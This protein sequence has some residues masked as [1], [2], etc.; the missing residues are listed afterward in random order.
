MREMAQELLDRTHRADLRTRDRPAGTAMPAGFEVVEARRIEDSTMW[1]RYARKCHEIQARGCKGL[2]VRT[3][4]ELRPAAQCQLNEGANEVYLLHGTSLESAEG[5][6]HS[7]F[8]LDLA[9]SAMGAAFGK[10]AYFAEC[11]TKSDEYARP[12]AE[13]RCAMVLCRVCLGEVYRVQ[14]FDP[15]G[16]LRVLN[17]G[18]YDSL[19]GDREARVG[20][21]REFVV[22][23]PQQIYPEYIITY[24]RR[25]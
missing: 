21:F 4:P 11:I 1:A 2:A 10:G 24:T 9:G 5:I 20:T 18:K 23:E 22:Y 3:T 17:S 14:D 7:G 6:A 12:D 13:M 25:D 16:E 15:E 8:R 19:L